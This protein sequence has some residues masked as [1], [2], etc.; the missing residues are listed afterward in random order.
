MSQRHSSS[1]FHILF[2]EVVDSQQYNIRLL[3]RCTIMTIVSEALIIAGQLAIL[4]YN[5]GILIYMLPIPLRSVKSWAPRLI[6]DGIY[7]ALLITLFST[8]L[9]VSDYI[10]SF[11]T[12]SLEDVASWINYMMNDIILA[13]LLTRIVSSFLY[14]IPG[15]GAI[16]SILLFPLGFIVFGMVSASAIAQALVHIIHGLKA[17]LAAIGVALYSLP[18]RIGRGAGASLLAFV[19]VGNIM[20][21][22]LPH[23][24]ML[25]MGGTTSS[26]INVA[27]RQGGSIEAASSPFWGL[28][29]DKWGDVPRYGIVFFSS[30]NITHGYPVEA[31]GSYYASYVLLPYGTYKVELE[32]MG[33]NLLSSKVYYTIPDDLQLTYEYS[34][35]PFRLDVTLSQ[36]VKLLKP[37]G[38]V[39]STAKIKEYTLAVDDND[40]TRLYTVRLEMDYTPYETITVIASLP[41]SCQVAM[42]KVDKLASN[43]EFNR[44]Y[45]AWRGVP[46]YTYMYS[47]IVYNTPF[48][49]ELVYAC[50]KNYI[51]Q[52]P[53]QAPITS[54]NKSIPLGVSSV[55]L[56]GTIYTMSIYSYLTLMG[57]MTMGL[58]RFLGAYYPRIIFRG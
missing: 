58:A 22:Y 48:S 39:Y 46:V 2:G 52:K 15:G 28:V 10:G 36:N 3:R 17:E 14:L 33:L 13:Y 43:I 18:F 41:E 9:Y 26:W 23:W 19:I 8:I 25:I 24:I 53:K 57:I 54:S 1:S 51:P 47:F 4:T 27:Y 20:L 42:F 44:T 6:E 56:F 49:I 50:P 31:D 45:K 5:I 55:I 40:N 38:V 7:A 34:D 30:Q 37:Q 11:S 29:R 32:Y 16:A 35:L 21:H 12:V